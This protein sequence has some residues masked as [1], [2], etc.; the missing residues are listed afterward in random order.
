MTSVAIKYH[1]GEY[2]RYPKCKTLFK[3]IEVRHWTYHFECGHWCTDTVFVDLIRVKK[4]I[5]VIND[6]Q[7]ELL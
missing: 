5:Q 1:I 6:I 4:G 2:Y 3:L 7:L